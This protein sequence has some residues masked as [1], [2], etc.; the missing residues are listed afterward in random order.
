MSDN[1]I[2]VLRADDNVGVAVDGLARGDSVTVGDIHLTASS[3]VPSGHKIAIRPI[4]T[5]GAVLKYGQL[6]GRASRDIQVGDH[7]HVHN[8]AMADEARREVGTAAVRADVQAVSMPTFEGYRRADGRWGTRN[9]IAV[10]TTVNCSASTARLIADQFRFGRGLE[11]FDHVDGVIA[12]THDTGCGLVPSSEGAQLTMRTLRGYADHPNVGGVLVLGL[13]C[14]MLQAQTL[15]NGLDLTKPVE[16]MIIQ[17][18]GGIRSTV[19]AGVSAIEK[20]LPVVD[21]ARRETAP[22]SAL[23]LGLNC[24]GSDGYSGISANPALGYASDQLVALGGTSI[25]AE[26]PEVFGAEHL[27]TARATDPTVSARLIE[28]IEWWREYMTRGGGTLDNN[29]SPGNK[30]GGLTTILEKSLGA[31]AKSGTA[32]LV[33]VHEYAERVAESGLVF[34]DTPGYDPVSVTGIVA[35]GAT[36]VVFTTGRGSVLGSKPSPTIKV[37]TNTAMY[38]RMREDMDINAGTIVDGKATV[39]EVGDQILA[40]ILA[41]ASGHPTVSEDLDLGA[42]EFVPWQLGAVT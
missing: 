4:A 9:Y 23:V 12:L 26:T 34:M 1:R 31:V 30:A 18:S 19:R 25:L 24:G 11:A 42:D 5:D 15:L 20:M 7:V 3:T 10:L 21:Q 36:V 22:A 16:T 6:I 8:L 27:L 35:G 33:A 17:E 38:E 2:L 14:E 29:P 28:R 41:V 40:E 13:G 37:A 39:E 32:P